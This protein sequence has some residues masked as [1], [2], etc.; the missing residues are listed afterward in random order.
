MA[1]ED[2]KGEPE[3]PIMTIAPRTNGGG[4]NSAK[5]LP[6]S[7]LGP[8]DRIISTASNFA[9]QPLNNSDPDVWGVLTAISNVA[10]KRPQV[11]TLYK[12]EAT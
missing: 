4:D 11:G 7:N 9:S 12:W 8:R 5:K 10:R 1:M 6:P 3:S 2:E